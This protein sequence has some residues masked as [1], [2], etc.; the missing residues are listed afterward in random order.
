MDQQVGNITR[1]LRQNGLEE[2][3]LVMF[4]S[5]NGPWEY[6]CEYA[7]YTGPYLGRWQKEH[8][9]GGSVNFVSYLG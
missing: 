1:F 8:G 2:D 3:T 7:G 6:K 5:D 4:T 9:G